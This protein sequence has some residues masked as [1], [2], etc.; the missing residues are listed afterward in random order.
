VHPDRGEAR[1]GGAEGLAVVE[2][3]EAIVK[4]IETDGPISVR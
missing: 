3:F 4:S 2:V 1:D